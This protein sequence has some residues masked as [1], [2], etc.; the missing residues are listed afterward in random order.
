[1]IFFAFLDKP[2]KAYAKSKTINNWTIRKRDQ[3][4]V[5]FSYVQMKLVL[6][7]HIDLPEADDGKFCRKPHIW[8]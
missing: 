4:G 6:Y 5:F 7:P 8:R 3:M 2:A 1:M